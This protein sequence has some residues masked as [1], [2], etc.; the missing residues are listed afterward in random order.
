M[1]QLQK[2]TCP[3][4]SGLTSIRREIVAPCNH[5]GLTVIGITIIVILLLELLVSKI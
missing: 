1:V 5:H 2:T 4:C 3:T